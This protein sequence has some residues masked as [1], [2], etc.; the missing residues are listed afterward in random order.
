MLQKFSILKGDLPDVPII[1][2]SV[3]G[4]NVVGRVCVGNSRGLLVPE[5]IN[6]LEFIK[7]QQTLPD[8]VK[9]Q[10]IDERLSALGNVIACNDRVA[11]IHPEISKVW[12]FF[13]FIIKS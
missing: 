13:S 3:S 1:S 7:L 9:V 5:S 8:S 2:T 10:K 4:C 6:E 12:M 11:L